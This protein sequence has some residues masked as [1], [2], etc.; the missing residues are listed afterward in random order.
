MLI[1]CSEKK[2]MNHREIDQK[3]LDILLDIQNWPG[4]GLDPKKSLFFIGP[5][6]VGKTHF[7][8]RWLAHQKR[9]INEIVAYDVE[10]GFVKEGLDYTHR[11]GYGDLFIDDIGI[12]SDLINSFG[13]KYYPIQTV[14][15]YRHRLF[16]YNNDLTHFTSN[17]NLTHIKKKYGDRVLDRLFEMCNLI[18]VTGRSYRQ[19]PYDG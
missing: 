15:F 3:N 5:P 7:M 9:H 17:L 1:A 12:E 6:G 14:I 4:L 11:F 16:I 13:T 19:F 18:I 2:K 8:K 10:K